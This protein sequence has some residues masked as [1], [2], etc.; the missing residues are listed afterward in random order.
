F[1]YHLAINFQEKA[2]EAWE[3]H[4]PS[5][6]DELKEAHRLLEQ[7]KK[8]AYGISDGSVIKALPLANSSEAGFSSNSQVGIPVTERQRSAT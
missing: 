3:G 4:G 2:I 5:A 6:V 7:L 1:S 8:K